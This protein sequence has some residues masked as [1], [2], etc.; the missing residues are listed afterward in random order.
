MP[1]RTADPP[2]QRLEVLDL[3]RGLAL[4]GMLL[5]HFQYYAS[6]G[7]GSAP[8]AV[9]GPIAGALGS[10]YTLFA[11]LFGA[12]FGFQLLRAQ[13]AGRPFGSFAAM[14]ARRLLVLAVLG[15][16]SETLTG[17]RVLNLYVLSG[18]ALL[19]LAR[20]SARTLAILAAASLL[21][22][23]AVTLAHGL[24]IRSTQGAAAAEEAAVAHKQAYR[25]MLQ[26][27]DQA[28]AAG[29]YRAIVAVQARQTLAAYADPWS[30][31][32]GEM[33]AL[34]LLGL[35][36]AKRGV[37]QALLGS[38]PEEPGPAG[39]SRR[40]RWALLACIACTA[41]GAAGMVFWSQWPEAD[42][43]F[44]PL[45]F[46]VGDAIGGVISDRWLGFAFAFFLVWLTFTSDRIR[47]ALSPVA[48]AGRLA[49]SFYLFHIFLLEL[50]L[51]G[52]WVQFELT[53]LALFLWAAA[54]YAAMMTFAHLWLRRFQYGP[55][56]WAWRSFA[57]F[58]L[59]P[60]RAG[61]ARSG[62]PR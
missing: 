56:E 58:A 9:L 54:L 52:Y 61:E 30:Y 47:W 41:L 5:V 15:Y 49:I 20:C 45:T 16:V 22:G 8:A 29:G 4:G 21:A 43:G 50:L 24:A 2:A 27:R 36:A 42:L 38:D 44:K 34:A 10:A 13:A 31:V 35:A 7:E 46:A 59:R 48:S 39:R 55:V 40:R 25:R 33:V 53:P 3:L 17:Y 6:G 1:P 57:H 19:P 51:G 60:M 26:E 37:F 18:F 12:G 14:M 62:T 11:F 23:P 28:K 32:P